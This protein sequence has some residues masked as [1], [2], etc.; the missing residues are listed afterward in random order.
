[1][2]KKI[3]STILNFVQAEQSSGIILIISTG[4]SLSIA[5]SFLGE[6]WDHF[7]N[8]TYF[9]FKNIGLEKSVVHWVNDGLMAI[10]FLL[11]GLEIKREIIEGELSSIKKSFLP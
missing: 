1:M 3:T 7:W 9:G 4:V 5:N 6:N 11:V 8:H 2:R 10:F